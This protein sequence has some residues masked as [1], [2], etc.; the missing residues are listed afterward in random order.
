MR[1]A[2]TIADIR[3]AVRDARAAGR[4]IHFVPTMGALHEGH[5]SLMRA[6]RGQDRFVVVSIFVNPIQFGPGEDFDRYP[7]PL[8]A[9]LDACRSES[10]DAVFAPSV[11]EM[12]PADAVTRVCVAGVTERLCGAHRP[13]HFDGVATV[14]AKLFHIVEPDAA[15]FGQKDGQ[16]CVVIRRMVAD[17]NMPVRIVVCPT[18]RE[19]DGLAL[20]SRNVYLSPDERRQAVCLSQALH[21]AEEQIRSGCRDAAA[22]VD[23]MRAVILAAGP[24]VIDYVEAVDAE[25]L[26]PLATLAGRCMLAVAVRIGTTRLIDNAVVDV[27]PPPQ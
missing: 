27:P 21:G 24:C 9:D 3:S 17:L 18:V 14:V 25:T 5:R 7:R 15:Y 19:P 22:V 10:V 23:G 8:E 6:A 26:Q 13:G 2:Q 20:S 16:Q 12:Y 1:L 4:T 11:A